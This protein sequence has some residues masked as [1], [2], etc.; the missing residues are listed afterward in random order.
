MEEYTVSFLQP[1][2]VVLSSLA[3]APRDDDGNKYISEAL[4]IFPASVTDGVL[5]K[6]AYLFLECSLLK[7]YDDFDENSLIAGRILAAHIQEDLLRMI[8]RD[9]QELLYQAPLLAYLNPGRYANIRETYSF[10]FHDGM[11]K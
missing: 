3:A 10:P 1:T 8:D 7:I 9:D 11:Q 4:E 6:D 5:V 2:Q